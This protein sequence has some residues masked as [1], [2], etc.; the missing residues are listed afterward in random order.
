MKEKEKA[1]EE[2]SMEQKGGKVEIRRRKSER[3]WR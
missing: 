1:E 2:D 3:I